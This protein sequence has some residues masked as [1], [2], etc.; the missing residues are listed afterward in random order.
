MSGRET[1]L[2]DPVPGTIWS[3]GG[4]TVRIL[5]VV[6][7]GKFEDVRVERLTGRTGLLKRP[8]SPS[9]IPMQAFHQG[10]MQPRDLT[11]NDVWTQAIRERYGRG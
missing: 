4:M 6:R 2:A 8:S 10:L 11:R 3:G 1:L 5:E 7:D 9:V